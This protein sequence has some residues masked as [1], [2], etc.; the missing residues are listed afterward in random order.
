VFIETIAWLLGDY[1]HKMPTEAL[2]SYQRNPQGPSPEIVALKGV[3]YAYANETVEGRHL[4]EA[5]VK[6]LTGGDTLTGRAPYGKAA[7]SFQPS[8]KLSVAGNHK[9]EISDASFGMWRRVM[10]VPFEETIPEAQ[11][12]PRLFEKL[13]AEGSGILNW[14]LQGLHAWQK[15]GLQVPKGIA[16]ATAAYRNEQD[17]L[18]EWLNEACTFGAG[19]DEPKANLYASYTYWCSQNGHKALAQGRLTRRLSDRGYKL[20]PDHRRILGLALKLGVP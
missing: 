11:R 20:A 18:L 1:A 12:D 13:K 10:L 15:E 2:M 17:I 14:A 9:P 4:D 6:D 3:R 16:A 5:R 19:L 7:I 8:L